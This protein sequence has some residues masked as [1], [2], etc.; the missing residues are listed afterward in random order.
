MEQTLRQF[1]AT[2][3][4]SGKGFGG[5]LGTIEQPNARESFRNPRREI[6]A[7]QS[8]EMSDVAEVLGGREFYVDARCLKDD[9]NLLAELVR[10]PGSVEAHDHSTPTC[11]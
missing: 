5:F 2:L 6:L 9:P 3:H 10:L 11:R 8:V 7:L 1:K 4:A